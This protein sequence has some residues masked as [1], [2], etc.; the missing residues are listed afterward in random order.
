MWSVW[1]HEGPSGPMWSTGP[2]G[3]M[4]PMGPYGPMWGQLGP[5]E[6]AERKLTADARRPTFLT[7]S[8]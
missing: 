3:L 6:L 8:N 4:W 1:A 7:K 2:Y 5:N